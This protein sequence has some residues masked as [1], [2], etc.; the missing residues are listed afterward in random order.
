MFHHP[1]NEIILGPFTILY[2]PQLHSTVHNYCAA[3]FN[4][5]YP[6]PL[7][8]LSSSTSWFWKVFLD[9]HDSTSSFILRTSHF[10]YTSNYY[11]LYSYI[12]LYPSNTP[13]THVPFQP[14]IACCTTS[15]SDARPLSSRTCLVRH[16]PVRGGGDGM[17][18]S[19]QVSCWSGARARIRETTLPHCIHLSV[20]TPALGESLPQRITSYTACF[21][22]QLTCYGDGD[23]RM[24]KVD[25]KSV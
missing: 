18:S 1:L 21:C 4:F 16:L 12:W 24:Q 5:L 6:E 14:F 25:K 10:P 15:P 3:V 13:K 20:C 2:F 19:P 8:S 23:C 9:S 7:L 17:P 22:N 11:T